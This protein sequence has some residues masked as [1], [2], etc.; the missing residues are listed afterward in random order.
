[1]K[2]KWSKVAAVEI[3]A[4]IKETH[5]EDVHIS[6]FLDVFTRQKKKTS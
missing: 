6:D 3:K 1:M 5:V 2:V 4:G